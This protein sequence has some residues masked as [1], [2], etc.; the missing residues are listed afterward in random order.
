[1]AEIPLR[2]LELGDPISCPP[3]LPDLAEIPLQ[4]QAALEEHLAMPGE[5]Q[6]AMLDFA[7][8]AARLEDGVRAAQAGVG[9]AASAVGEARDSLRAAEERRQVS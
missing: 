1:M 3:H 4:A 8:V 5:A 9:R 6:L 2:F 7:G